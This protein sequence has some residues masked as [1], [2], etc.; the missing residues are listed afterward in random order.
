MH[1]IS[2][3]GVGGVEALEGEV[4][5]AQEAEELDEHTVA[6]VGHGVDES[7]VRV[8][9]DGGVEAQEAEELDKHAVGRVGRG[10]GVEAQEAEEMDEHVVAEPVG[11]GGGEGLDRL[12]GEDCACCW[13]LLNW[14][15]THWVANQ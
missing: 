9:R 15:I 4:P 10:G 3:G 1:Y 2:N 5:V 11:R 12:A 14:G 7:L 8:G 13:E 6:R